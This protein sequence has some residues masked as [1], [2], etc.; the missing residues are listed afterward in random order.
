ME[1]QIQK[2]DSFMRSKNA[3]LYGVLTLVGAG[4]IYYAYKRM[5]PTTL[6][7]EAKG[8][9]L[10]MGY[11]QQNNKGTYVHF[12]APRPQFRDAMPF[13][14]ATMWDVYIKN[15]GNLNGKH[16]ILGTWTDANGR[17]GA[18]KI[19]APMVPNKDSKGKSTEYEGKGR[20]KFKHIYQE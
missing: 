3:L 13:D 5:F 20:M 10:L 9:G 11:V 7:Q 17:L 19:S 14:S 2:V 8:K 16:R 18:I 12:Q 15:A 1:K 6:E 4:V